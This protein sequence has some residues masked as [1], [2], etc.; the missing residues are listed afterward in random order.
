MK[1]KANKNKQKKIMK[2]EVRLSERRQDDDD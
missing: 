2:G 1:T